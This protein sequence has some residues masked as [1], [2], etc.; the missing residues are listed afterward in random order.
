VVP[1]A[2]TAASSLALIADRLPFVQFELAGT[3]GLEPGR[4]LAHPDSDDGSERVIVV[5]IQ[6]APAPPRRR[7]GR[8]RPRPAEPGS[9]PTVP[10][11]TIT[12]VRSE[13][14]GDAGSAGRWLTEMRT[15]PDRL[16]AAVDDALSLVNRAVH[17]HRA[18][19]L[20]PGLADLTT[21]HALAIRAGFGDGAELADGRF[22]EAIELPR[23]ERRARAEALRPQERL[24][25]VLAGRETVQPF[26]LTLLR[27]RSDL[28]S[29]RGREAGLQLRIGL[30]ALLAG[31]ATL[32]APGQQADLAALEGRLQAVVDTADE[33]L[34][35]ELSAERTAE[36]DET[37][38]IAERVL[39]RQR[40]TG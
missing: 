39:R 28:D 33:S 40:A 30:E 11:T 6:G 4:Y 15:D 20:D 36:L 3:V 7:L 29:G 22:G 21:E 17:A 19:V 38:K 16:A 10:L 5:G 25:A 27:A 8:P 31:R 14:L 35:G 2:R 18:T 32:D 13:P 12:V 37:L 34:T 24:A 23:S 1:R 26:E 9:V